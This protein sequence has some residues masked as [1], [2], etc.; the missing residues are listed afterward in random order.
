MDEIITEELFKKYTRTFFPEYRFEEIHGSD[1]ISRHY[2]LGTPNVVKLG[3]VTVQKFFEIVIPEMLRKKKIPCKTFINSL[4]GFILSDKTTLQRSYPPEFLKNIANS[5]AIDSIL[6]IIF[7]AGGSFLMDKICSSTQSETDVGKKFKPL[8]LPLLKDLYS[9]HKKWTG[10]AMNIQRVI[11]PFIDAR[12]CGDI[13][14]GTE[15]WSLFANAFTDLQFDYV[16]VYKRG[17]GNKPVKH[18]YLDFQ[19]DPPTKYLDADFL[20][21][22]DDNAP[23]TQNLLP[24]HDLQVGGY[25]LKAVLFFKGMIH[26][27]S[28]INTPSGWVYY[29]DFSGRVVGIKNP[30]EYI[31]NE[32]PSHKVQMLFYKKV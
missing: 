24:V 5:C 25:E 32:S 23:V 30:R 18:T 19:M 20:I 15:I 4:D 2:D 7:F 14:S 8:I 3:N 31:F 16:S 9:H 28:A 27:T 10:N 12:S 22:G 17:L 21:Y 1:E 11:F 26:Y 13:K 6:F 29:D